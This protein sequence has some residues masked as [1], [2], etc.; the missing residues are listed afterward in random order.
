MV[1]IVSG[2]RSVLDRI[3]A[4]KTFEPEDTPS[5]VRGMIQSLTVERIAET[6]SA[7]VIAVTSIVVDITIAELKVRRQEGNRAQI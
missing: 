3:A 5:D 6:R 4:P 2:A 1:A 7:W